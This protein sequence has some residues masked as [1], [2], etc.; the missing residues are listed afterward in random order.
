MKPEKVPKNIH[1]GLE[2][3]PLSCNSAR[4][5][6]S[7]SFLLERCPLLPRGKR[8]QEICFWLALL[9]WPG[10]GRFNRP[11]PYLLLQ[12]ATSHCSAADDRGSNFRGEQ[13]LCGVSHQHYPDFSGQS[14]RS[15]LF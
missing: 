10:F 9:C 4:R 13:G 14:P 3:S 15:P 5:A 1:A 6:T 8:L 7:T 12:S 11:G 2:I